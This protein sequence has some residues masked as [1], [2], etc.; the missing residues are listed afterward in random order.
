MAELTQK[1]RLQPSLLDRLSDDS[2]TE[3]NESRDARVLSLKKLR[4]CVLR[5]LTWLLNTESFESVADLD[6]LPAVKSSVLNYGIPT[7]AGLT[8]SGIEL[9][10]LERHVKNAII[11]FEPRLL[12]DKLTVQALLSEEEMSRNTL[13]FEINGELWAQPVPLRMQLRTELDLETGKVLVVETYQ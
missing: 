1:E 12:K 7:I 11:A 9:G 13:V 3:L 5:D 8:A 6:S 10:K 4:E 2:P